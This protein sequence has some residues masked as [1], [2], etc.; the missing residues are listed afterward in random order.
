MSRFSSLFGMV[1]SFEER[2]SG[3]RRILQH[4]RDGSGDANVG[5]RAQDYEETKRGDSSRMTARSHGI[6]VVGRDVRGNNVGVLLIL[7]FGRFCG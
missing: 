2:Q 1:V 4:I 6:A 5:N 7:L 3:R